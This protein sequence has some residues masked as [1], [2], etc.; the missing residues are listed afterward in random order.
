MLARACGECNVGSCSQPL[1]RR[2]R[3]AI[4]TAPGT[5]GL[6]A[7]QWIS[8]NDGFETF[9]RWAGCAAQAAAVSLLAPRHQGA[10]PDHWRIC[11]CS[12]ADSHR[13]RTRPARKD[14]RGAR[15]GTLR[16]ADQRRPRAAGRCRRGVRQDESGSPGGRRQM[17]SPTRSGSPAELLKVG[18]P[19]TLANAADGAEGLVAADLARSIAVRKS[20]PAVSLAVVCRD[21]GRMAQL[22]RALDFFA[23]DIA[24]LQ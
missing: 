5:S 15:T 20:P 17:T 24:L 11:R 3:I 14:H 23:P 21:A 12:P 1:T 22:A 16:C 13:R 19:L 7:L 2:W 6:L 9:K 10:R 18:Q 8:G 4:S